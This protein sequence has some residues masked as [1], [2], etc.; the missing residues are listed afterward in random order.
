MIRHLGVFIMEA[1]EKLNNVKN[2]W[3]VGHIKNIT[4]DYKISSEDAVNRRLES[5]KKLSL[6]KKISFIFGT[7]FFI[8]SNIKWPPPRNKHTFNLRYQIYLEKKMVSFF[9][10]SENTLKEILLETKYL[11]DLALEENA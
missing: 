8:V 7:C 11:H 2:K 4:D 5:I 6:E 10:N 9:L 1:N 3:P